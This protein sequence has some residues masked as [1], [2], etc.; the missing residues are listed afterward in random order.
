M[1][2]MALYTYDA[3][4]TLKMTDALKKRLDSMRL[5]SGIETAEMLRQL[6]T[7]A[8]DYYE[9]IGRFHLPALVVPASDFEFFGKTEIKARELGEAV[10]AR[11]A[12]FRRANNK[13]SQAA[14]DAKPKVA[15]RRVYSASKILRPLGGEMEFAGQKIDYMLLKPPSKRDFTRQAQA[16]ADYRAKT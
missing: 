4:I 2:S 15:A 3:Q 1:D 7:A 13:R 16:A 8:V 11:L 9:G 10:K 12:D 6:A 5:Q 14:Q